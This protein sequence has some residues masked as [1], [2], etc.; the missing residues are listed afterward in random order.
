VEFGIFTQMHVPVG[1]T[2]HSRFRREVEQACAADAAGFK[3]DWAPEH[4]CLQEYSHQP[5]PEVFLSFVAARTKQIHLGHAIVNLTAKVNHPARVAERIA[6]LDHLSEGR[7]EF[8]TGRGS[9]TTE[10][11]G[12]DIPSAAETKPMWWESIQEI[13]KMWRDEPY[14]FEGQYFRMPKRNVL[15]KPYQKPHPPIWVACSSPPTFVQ[16]GELGIGALCFTTGTVQEIEENVRAYK[17]AIQR[18]KK[19]LGDYV[20]DHIMVTGSMFC[21][22]DGD[23]A[24]HIFCHSRPEHYV[25]LLLTWLDSIPRPKYLPQTGPVKL[26]PYTPEMLKERMKVGGQLIGAPEEII[27]CIRLYEGIGVDSLV[28]APLVTTMEQKYVLRSIETF[29]SRVIPLFDKDPVHSTTLA[30]EAALAEQSS[31]TATA[32]TRTAAVARG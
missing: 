19:P 2:E 24:R 17:D 32:G 18:C 27:E 31:S 13:P 26:S 5:A 25:E 28:F 21:L 1:E 30:R 15:P 14:E 6:T 16:A 7:V 20:N 12:Y 10:W 22:E 3:Y 29:G 9:S 11:A 8:G 4:H 23:E